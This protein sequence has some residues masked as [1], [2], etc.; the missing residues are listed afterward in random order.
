MRAELS[1]RP[2][3]RASSPGQRLAEVDPEAAARIPANNRFA[4]SAPSKYR[5]TGRPISSFGKDR[6][7]LLRSRG[8]TR[9]VFPAVVAKM[10]ATHLLHHPAARG[11]ERITALAAM[12]PGILDENRRLRSAGQD[13]SPRSRARLPRSLETAWRAA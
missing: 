1:A 12:W 7:P 5:L 3:S 2:I 6:R 8:G 9:P 4:S 13:A 11:S 10:A